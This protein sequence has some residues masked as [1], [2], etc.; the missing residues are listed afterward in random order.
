MSKQMCQPATPHEMN[1]RSMFCHSVRR[2]PPPRASSSHRI[3]LYSGTLG[4]RSPHSCFLRRGS[5]PGE[6]HPGSNRTQ[7]PIDV[8][9]R[10]PAQM[11]RVS[12][13]LPGFFRRVGQFSD[14]NERPLLSVLSYLCPAGPTRRALLSIT[15]FVPLSSS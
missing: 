12:K 5:H 6:L 13:R 14:E 4:A 7:A 11:H 9:G 3:S 1:R 15:F 8:E 10:P 2:L